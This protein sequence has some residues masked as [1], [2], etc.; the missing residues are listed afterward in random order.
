[1]TS[2]QHIYE[3]QARDGQ[4]VTVARHRTDFIVRVGGWRVA[5]LKTERG[6]MS[7]AETEE[8]RER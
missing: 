1:M 4:P 8:A 5:T 7:R 6:A 3:G 2:T